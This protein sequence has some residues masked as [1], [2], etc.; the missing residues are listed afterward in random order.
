MNTANLLDGQGT[1]A[2]RL[3]CNPEV[4]V[5]RHGDALY[6]Y[7]LLRLRDGQKAQD[8]VQ[9]T[10]LAAL[11]AQ[12]SFAG[13]SSERT[14]LIGI[15]KHKIID[16]FR[17]TSREAPAAFDAEPVGR[18]E[19]FFRVTPPWIRHWEKEA[20]PTDWG[21]TPGPD[22]LVESRAFWTA[23]QECLNH[24]PPRMA[25]AFILRE[26]D[27]MSTEE[28]CSTLQIT[29]SNFWVLIHRARLRLRRCLETKYFSK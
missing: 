16:D 17:K 7:A 26:M 22:A 12:G 19:D 6:R 4:W 23:L 10:F 8:A 1:A 20:A 3:T 18:G 29:A 11:R 27:D 24:M 9:E 5:D 14:W 15:L 25:R 2:K 28:I 13:Q 21:L